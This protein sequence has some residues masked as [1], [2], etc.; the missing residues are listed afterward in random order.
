[1]NQAVWNIGDTCILK[2]LGAFKGGVGTIALVGEN[3]R[4]EAYYVVS[5][6]MGRSWHRESHEIARPKEIV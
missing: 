3:L 1:M 6:Q 5:D 2:P 4:N